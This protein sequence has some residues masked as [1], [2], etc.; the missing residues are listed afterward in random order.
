[1]VIRS[2]RETRFG[3]HDELVIVADLALPEDFEPVG[4][5]GEVESFHCMGI[6]EVETAI[7]AGEFTVEAALATRESIARRG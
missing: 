1:M 6:A 7:A 4:R 3:V 5:D 2:L